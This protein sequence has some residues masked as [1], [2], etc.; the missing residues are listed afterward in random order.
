MIDG[1][2]NDW[3]DILEPFYGK[4]GGL[5]C[6]PLATRTRRQGGQGIFTAWEDPEGDYGSYGLSGWVCDADPGAAFGDPLYW[7]EAA[8]GGTQNIP[9]FLDCL[10]VA[11]WPDHTSAPPPLTASDPRQS[12]CRD[13]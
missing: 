2:W 8:V 5:T 1:W 7:R 4:V 10:G 9:V 13:R 12:V 3:I 11:G 6:C